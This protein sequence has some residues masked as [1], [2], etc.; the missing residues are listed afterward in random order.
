[1]ATQSP[2]APTTPNDTLKRLI[3]PGIRNFL[4]AGILLGAMLCLLAGT[5]RYWQGWVWVILFDTLTTG[6][7]IYLGIKDPELLKRRQNIAPTGQ[8][9][10]QKI[11]M[12]ITFVSIAC[13]LIAS[14]LDYRFGWSQ[15]SPVISVIG[16]ASIVFSFYLYYVVFRENSYAATRIETFEDQKVI[17]TGPYALVRHP[18]Y[19][20]DLFLLVGTPLA[21]GSWWGLVFVV[22]TLPG[23]ALRIL[24]EEK[25]LRQ[26]LPGYAE[27]TQKVRYRLV[28]HVW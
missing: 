14:A 24:D 22:L 12:G 10:A 25:L 9:T 13:L 27:Y 17:S 16:D 3:L 21:L 19:V 8:S 23:L 26:E 2:P 7:G 1:M 28:P 4:I 6:Q 18:K 15:M 11:F 20:G 5:L